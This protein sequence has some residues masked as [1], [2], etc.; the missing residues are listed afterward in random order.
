MRETRDRVSNWLASDDPLWMAYLVG[1]AGDPPPARHPRA[2]RLAAA[3]VL[4][5][6]RTVAAFTGRA[7]IEF[8][9]ATA[10]ALDSGPIMWGGPAIR[11]FGQWCHR[12]L[13]P[14]AHEQSGL[15]EDGANDLI[16]VALARSDR[17][18]VGLIGDLRRR[19]DWFGSQY[20]WPAVAKTAANALREVFGTP[21]LVYRSVPSPSA[22]KSPRWD[23]NPLSESRRTDTVLSLART[24]YEA[25]EF[26]AMPILA[27][28][29][30]DAGCD[31]EDV[32]SHCRD[33]HTAH[34][35]GC[36]VLDAILVPTGG[37]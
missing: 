27:D 16:R 31:R 3:A 11:D 12:T 30:Q 9:A 4:R 37:K 19:C 18:F 26:S 24:M 33:P 17:D 10:D 5:S 32:L 14:V 8:L 7:D 34:C 21:S 36:W 25:R 22:R 23:P 13:Y 28:A 35:R 2:F 29:L 20:D 15:D 6:L 1:D